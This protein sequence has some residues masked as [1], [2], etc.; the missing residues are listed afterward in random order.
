[1]THVL[2]KAPTSNH[3]G[4]M[5]TDRHVKSPTHFVLTCVLNQVWP[6]QTRSW[7]IQHGCCCEHED[8]LHT[9]KLGIATTGPFC[10]L[11]ALCA[12]CSSCVEFVRPVF[13][14]RMGLG[15]FIQACQVP[16]LFHHSSSL[17]VKAM[18]PMQPA[19]TAAMP[20]LQVSQQTD[21][22]LQ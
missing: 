8:T 9:S 22:V 7:E 12:L 3:H 14:R 17:W 11:V 21:H 16:G 4:I 2:V 6:A 13:C 10:L 20:H 18:H 5:M 15:S 19:A 1:M